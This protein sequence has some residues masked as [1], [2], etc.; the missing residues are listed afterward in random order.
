MGRDGSVGS[1]GCVGEVGVVEGSVGSVSVDVVGS[2]VGVVDSVGCVVGAGSDGSV[3]VSSSFWSGVLSPCAATVS[4][5]AV[6][7]AVSSA[8]AES[9]IVSTSTTASNPAKIF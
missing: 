9:G 5:V 2:V 3:E 7:S 4:S 1:E 8:K 6:V